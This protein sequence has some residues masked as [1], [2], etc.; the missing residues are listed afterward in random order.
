MRTGSRAAA[1]PA[2]APTTNFGGYRR[3]GA[4]DFLD[5]WIEFRAAK[6]SKVECMGSRIGHRIHPRSVGCLPRIP[7]VVA[8]DRVGS[9]KT[10]VPQE[11]H[12]RG[13]FGSEG[14]LC[15]G[16]EYPPLVISMHAW[17]SVMVCGGTRP[18]HLDA[19][20]YMY[21]STEK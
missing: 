16:V 13:V 18:A 17:H 12:P 6:S 19:S 21:K 7:R 20:I 10:W 15:L 3:S 5:S 8:G 11:L 1:A 4:G 9:E 2:P 14:E